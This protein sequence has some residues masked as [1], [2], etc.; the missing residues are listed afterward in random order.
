[1]L[2]ILDIQKQNFFWNF[3]IFGD[4]DK[5]KGFFQSYLKKTYFSS[6]CGFWR[7][8]GI[9]RIRVRRP[10]SRNVG[11][12][13]YMGKNK[14]FPNRSKKWI[15][16]PG[17]LIFSEIWTKSVLSQE[18]FFSSIC[19]YYRIYGQKTC[20]RVIS[21]ST[22]FWKW[23]YFWTYWLKKFSTISFTWIL[24]FSDIWTKSDLLKIIS[25]NAL[26]FDMLIYANI[27]KKKQRFLQ[28]ISKNVL[29]F[30]MFTYAKIWIKKV[31]IHNDLK[32]H[33]FLRYVDI[34]GYMNKKR[35]L[36]VISKKFLF[37]EMMIFLHLLVQA[38][39]FNEI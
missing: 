32:K 16:Y 14:I 4:M 3:D 22:F 33:S 9:F 1:M 2:V 11:N 31:V 28:L 20:L 29:F 6:K 10:F 34:I 36:R 24:I 7:I 8:Y 5:K 26:F 23:W 37:L 17:V 39:F 27:L 35:C 38:I 30:D 19:W 18:T 13:G 25:K 12:F 15:S 21:K